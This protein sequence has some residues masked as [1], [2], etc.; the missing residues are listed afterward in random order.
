[1]DPVSVKRHTLSCCL[2]VSSRFPCHRL[3]LWVGATDFAAEMSA[4]HLAYSSP[5]LPL[6]AILRIIHKGSSSKSRS[7]KGSRQ[8]RI[9]SA[10]L[11]IGGGAKPREL[12]RDFGLAMFDDSSGTNSPG[13]EIGVPVRR[14]VMLA[15]MN[16]RRA[17]SLKQWAAHT[18][19]REIRAHAAAGWQLKRAMDEFHSQNW[20]R[21]TCGRPSSASVAES[22]TEVFRLFESEANGEWASKTTI[23]HQQRTELCDGRSPMVTARRPAPFSLMRRKKIIICIPYRY[24]PQGSWLMFRG[25]STLHNGRA[26]TG[27]LSDSCC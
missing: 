9:N 10:G 4:I 23:S 2:A 5:C 13:C 6:A 3:I 21:R 18:G 8:A 1:M 12:A 27:L 16:P 20:P 25:G 11:E 19:D 15:A 22:V 14:P 7:L 24:S 26:P 17:D